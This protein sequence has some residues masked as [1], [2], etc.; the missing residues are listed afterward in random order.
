MELEDTQPFG[1]SSFHIIPQ[2]YGTVKICYHKSSE[3]IFKLFFHNWLS[4]TY[5]RNRRSKLSSLDTTQKRFA[6]SVYITYKELVVTFKSDPSKE[7]ISNAM[8]RSWCTNDNF[9][10]LHVRVL[11]HATYNTTNTRCD[12]TFE[13]QMN[14]SSH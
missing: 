9:M 6:V 3:Y 2:S 8:A 14:N 13:N 1:A 10:L 12:M 7:L 4:T 5:R 11:P